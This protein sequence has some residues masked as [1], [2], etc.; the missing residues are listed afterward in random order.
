MERYLSK[1][2]AAEAIGVNIRTVERYLTSGRLPGARLE[3]SWRIAESDVEAF[4]ES[5]KTAT[6]EALKEAG[7][8][9]EYKPRIEFSGG[10]EA[11]AKGIAKIKAANVKTG[12]PRK[13]KA[14]APRG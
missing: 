5:V 9:K 8:L 7:S 6:R 3:K 12:T 1:K 13:A 10:R 14:D 2:E 11:A 4:M